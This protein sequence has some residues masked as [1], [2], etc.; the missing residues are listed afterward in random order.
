MSIAAL[1]FS[2]PDVLPYVRKKP[3]KKE[4]IMICRKVI[5]QKL[6][7]F[8]QMMKKRQRKIFACVACAV[9]LDGIFI[10]KIF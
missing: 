5:S 7:L 6:A 9:F 2:L 8:E 3:L 4:K 10:C 1:Q